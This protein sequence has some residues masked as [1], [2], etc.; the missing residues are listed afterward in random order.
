MAEHIQASDIEESF[1]LVKTGQ[2][3]LNSLKETQ[4]RELELRRVA[5][6]QVEFRQRYGD[7]DGM[8]IEWSGQLRDIDNDLLEGAREIQEVE[9]EVAGVQ[10]DHDALLM[11]QSEFE[12]IK[13]G[14]IK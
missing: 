12:R 2:D 1:L 4:D 9:D 14:D 3:L 10:R 13:N 6:E 8:L 11:V 5:F 7:T